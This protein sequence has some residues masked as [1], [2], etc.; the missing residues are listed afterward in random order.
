[1]LMTK[2][3]YLNNPT[4][5]QAKKVEE[6]FAGHNITADFVDSGDAAEVTV[7]WPGERRECDESNLYAEGYST[8]PAAF[9]TAVKLGVDRDVFGRL[10]NTL[11]I[12][13]KGCQFGCF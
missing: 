10:L 4:P 7:H 9:K 2:S 13:L 1:M 12:K 5:E 3:I 6:F 8:C 11:E